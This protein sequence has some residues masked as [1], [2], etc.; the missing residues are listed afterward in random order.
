[1]L[2]MDRIPLYHIV[3]LPHHNLTGKRIDQYYQE[4][5]DQYS[6]FDRIVIIS[7]DHF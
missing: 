2:I 6:H 1:M 5:H 7:P 3:I 4:L